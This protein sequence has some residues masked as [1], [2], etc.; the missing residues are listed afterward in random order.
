MANSKHCK[1]LNDLKLKKIGCVHTIYSRKKSS[2]GRIQLTN[3]YNW[4]NIL[5]SISSFK[6]F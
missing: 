3:S 4:I 2:E 6:T 5:M 1:N